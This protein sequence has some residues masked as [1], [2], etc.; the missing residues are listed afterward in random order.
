ESK[1]EYFHES[2]VRN[3]P[4]VAVAALMLLS[5][6]D[7]GALQNQRPESSSRPEP[8]NMRLVGYSDLQGRSAFQPI[9][10]EQ[11]GRWIAYVG[12]HGGT[13]VNPLTAQAEADGSSIIDVSDPKRPRYL[14]HLPTASEGTITGGEGSGA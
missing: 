4:A 11:S 5:C 13:A 12:H 1:Q 14:H 8:L 2:G 9:I 6:S 7:F 10:V 3:P